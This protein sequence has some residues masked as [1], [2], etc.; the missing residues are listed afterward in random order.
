MRGGG[1]NRDKAPDFVNKNFINKTTH[2]GL[3]YAGA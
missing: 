1:G 3:T 2:L